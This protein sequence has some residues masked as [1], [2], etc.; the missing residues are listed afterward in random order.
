M[1]VLTSFQ[2]ILFVHALLWSLIAKCRRGCYIVGKSYTSSSQIFPSGTCLNF[3]GS[4]T[5]STSKP[6]YQH[7]PQKT[8]M[9]APQQGTK[10]QQPQVWLHNDTAIDLSASRYDSNSFPCNCCKEF[11]N[12]CA[13]FMRKSNYWM[14][15]D[16]IVVLAEDL[17]K[18]YQLHLGESCVK[19]VHN[20]TSPE[21]KRTDIPLWWSHSKNSG[22]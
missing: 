6:M 14:S 16:K 13:W 10:R 19:Y 4:C 8:D 17:G 3:W 11:I 2:Y 12:L 20:L 1:T 21:S 7:N 22:Y 5:V 15:S 18:I 9:L